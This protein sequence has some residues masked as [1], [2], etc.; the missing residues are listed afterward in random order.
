[1]ASALQAIVNASATFQ[2]PTVGTVTDPLTGNVSAATEEVTATFYLKRDRFRPNDLPGVEVYDDIFAGYAIEPAALDA[3]IKR[4][5]EG[6]LTFAADEPL[7]CKISQVQGDWGRS[8][9]IGQT[10]T[11]VIGDNVRIIRYQ[12]G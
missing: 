2:V 4:A 5:T 11:S 12:Q 9:L 6:T 10:L 1:M 8:G 3:R 7:P